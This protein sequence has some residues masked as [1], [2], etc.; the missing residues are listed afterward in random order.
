M[1]DSV[2]AIGSVLSFPERGPWGDAAWR[3]N[4]S[5]HIY[6]TLFERFQPRSFC[7]PMVGS[8]T[9]VEVAAE[10]GIIAFGLDLHS[11]FNILRDSIRTVIGQEVDIC[12]SHPPYGDMIAYSGAVWGDGPYTD[13][14]SR[15][16]G[17]EEFLD[18]LQLA[19]FNQ[20][21]A[22]KDGGLYG[23]IIGDKRR[24]GAY[25]SYQAGA[26]ARLPA[27]ELK[28]VLVKHQHNT[29]S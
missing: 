14:L 21:E 8:G 13:D 18:K 9:S 11:G 28:A 16:A 26:I 6:R 19:I 29:L 17:D 15:C 27:S 5:G 25:V 4:C 24:H 20:R 10:M 7:D 1:T 2:N 22:V 23:I 3:G 12:L